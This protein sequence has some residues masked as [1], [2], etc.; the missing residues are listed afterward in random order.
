MKGYFFPWKN[1]SS[2]NFISASFMANLI[3]ILKINK[4]FLKYSFGVLK[5]SFF[6]PI[7]KCV[8]ILKKWENDGGVWKSGV[9]F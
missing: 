6:F 7:L 3:K 8:D 9:N 2:S 5:F 1:S 4:K